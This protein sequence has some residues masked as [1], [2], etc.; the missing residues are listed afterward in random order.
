MSR[1]YNGKRIVGDSGCP[2]CISHG[3]DRTLN[4]LQHWENDVGESWVYCSKCGH[5]EFL[6]DTNREAFTSSRKVYVEPSPEEVA[7]KI[8]EVLECPIQPL[9]SRSIDLSV[10]ERYGVRVGLSAVDGYSQVNHFYPK[11]R[12]GVVTGY[13]VRDLGNKFFYSVG[14]GRG[15]DFFGIEQ[16]KRSDVHTSKLFV[17]EDELSAMSG[18]QCLKAHT[19]KDF[20][21]FSPACVALPDGT[22]SAGRVF[23]QNREFVDSFTDIVVCMDNDEAGEEAARVIQMLYPSAMVAKLPLK[24]AND[25]LM[26]G[27]SRELFDNLRFKAKKVSPDHALNVVDC[28]EDALKKPEWGKSYPW[29]G[30][31]KLT[32]GL[33]YGE[34]IAI[35]AGTSLGKSLL[36]HELAAHL[37]TVEGERV[38]MFMLEETVGNT[39]K[40]VCGKIDKVPYHRPDVDFDPERLR[41]TALSLNEKIFLWNNF[42]VNSWDHI[43]QCIRFW[44]VTEGC[45]FI[46]L[47]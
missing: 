37:T 20:A 8:A 3:R 44:V 11:T 24:D 23:A 10:A 41:K 35:G 40:N 16:A 22:Q 30:L 47:D 6:T 39:V 7:S 46:I 2:T 13:K 33:R 12:E 18:F 26:E 29:D 9:T 4:H 21:H 36:G 15:C 45:K 38:G 42:G 5:H 32:Y 28:I 17:F 31:T 19:K 25:M 27:R 34:I 43:K 14:S 1:E